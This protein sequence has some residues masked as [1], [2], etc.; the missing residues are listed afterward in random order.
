MG[1]QNSK[2]KPLPPLPS[3]KEMREEKDEIEYQEK[4]RK[5]ERYIKLNPGFGTEIGKITGNYG[6]L[7]DGLRLDAQK[8]NSRNVSQVWVHPFG[9]FTRF[10]PKQDIDLAD[11]HFL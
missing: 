5:I 10:Y 4:L 7:W 8:F 9:D 3:L 2:N 6:C 11:P 1:C